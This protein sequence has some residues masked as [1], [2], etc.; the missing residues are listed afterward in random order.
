MYYNSCYLIEK[1]L[2][3]KHWSKFEIRIKS[4]ELNKRPGTETQ[5]RTNLLTGRVKVLRNVNDKKAL[6]EQSLPRRFSSE[7]VSYADSD[8]RPCVTEN[9]SQFFF[10][11]RCLFVVLMEGAQQDA[12]PPAKLGTFTIPLNDLENQCPVGSSFTFSGDLT[13][14][15]ILAGGN[16]NIEVRRKRETS[17]PEVM[18]EISKKL[19]YEIVSD[20]KQFND[21]NIKDSLKLSANIRGRL[22]VTLLHAAIELQREDLVKKLVDLGANAYEKSHLGTPHSLA[23]TY[24]GR[25]EEKWERKSR[26]GDEANVKAQMAIYDNYKRIVGILKSQ[27]TL[28][29]FSGDNTELSEDLAASGKSKSIPKS[30]LQVLGEVFAFA[31]ETSDKG[32]VLP[33]TA[34]D[35]GAFID[36]RETCL[37]KTFVTFI[38][39]TKF[40]EQFP[41]ID[42]V[43]KF[44]DQAL[45]SKQLIR[46]NGSKLKRGSPS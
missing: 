27:E 14:G 16:I 37:Y 4:I 28:A 15:K 26:A 17:I 12:A 36:R 31:P 3:L 13:P 6:F 22:N 39:R 9:N 33:S 38:L 42:S 23:L 46:V 1:S 11:N 35:D 2:S 25:A 41:D 29:P 21:R 8:M 43:N 18:S 10:E 34:D 44:L 40:A 19:K 5:G 20:I 45:S 24:F 7:I 30:V 32:Y